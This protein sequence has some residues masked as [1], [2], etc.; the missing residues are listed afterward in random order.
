MLVVIK[1]LVDGKDQVEV[2]SGLG[3][4]SIQY[5]LFVYEIRAC[6]QYA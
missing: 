6:W 4:S 2:F 5:T 1:K 3:V